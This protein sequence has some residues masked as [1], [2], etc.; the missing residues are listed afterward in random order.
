MNSI[1]PC[2]TPDFEPTAFQ[3]AF[4]LHHNCFPL[5]VLQSVSLD[6]PTAYIS[7]C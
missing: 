6:V 7:A 2:L 1:A 5:I 4:I 3:V